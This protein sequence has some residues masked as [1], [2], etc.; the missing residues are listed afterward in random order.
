MIIDNRLLKMHGPFHES[1]MIHHPSSM[2]KG[3]FVATVLANRQSGECFWKME[4][5]FT[6]A[7]AKAFARFHPG[8]FLQIDVSE[9]GLPPEDRIPPH[10]RDAC[11]RSVLLRRP[12]SFAEVSAEA[13]GPRPSFSIACSGRLPCG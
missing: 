13:D 3:L 6:G 7:G 5:E 10:L 1:S 4:L 11:R 9:V 2:P 12:F 8:Q